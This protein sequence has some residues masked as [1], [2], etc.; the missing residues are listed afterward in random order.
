MLRDNMKILVFSAHSADFCSRAGDTIAR[1]V[2]RGGTVQVVDLTYG[3]RCESPAL[4][5][6]TPAP[7]VAEVK[8]IRAKEIEAAAEILGASITCF[9]FDDSPLVLGPDRR[10]RILEA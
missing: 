6:R 7:R 4:W 10:L 1:A 8:R 9:D 3:E 5:A 2:E